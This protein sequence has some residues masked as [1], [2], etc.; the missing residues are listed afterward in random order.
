V[1]QLRADFC[2]RA[3]GFIITR[4]KFI[5]E[6]GFNIALTRLY[7]RAASGYRVTEGVPKNYG[8]NITMLAA[9]GI[10]GVSAPMTVEGSVDT[11]VFVVYIEQVLAP[12]LEPGDIVAMDNL[13]VHKVSKVEEA[14]TA[15]G[16]WIEYLPPY[17]PDL[18]PIEKCWSKIKTGLRKAKARTRESLESAI[19][20]ALLTITQS[21]ACAWFAHCG[22]TVHS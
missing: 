20:Q 19:K 3:A 10:S 21:D 6:T 4:L 18:N 9:L 22:Y 15:R 13:C 11:E 14:I 12:T 1:K 16:A 17:S 5:D 2:E 8:D 7:G